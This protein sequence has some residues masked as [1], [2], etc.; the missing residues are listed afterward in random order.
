MANNWISKLSTNIKFK[1]LVIK[2]DFEGRTL[3]QNAPVLTIV[4]IYIIIYRGWNPQMGPS[5]LNCFFWGD[6]F[7]I[8]LAKFKI[9][10]K[11]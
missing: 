1:A 11:K 10:K 8:K 4:V 6:Q 5:F 3:I 2:I 9:P 7:N